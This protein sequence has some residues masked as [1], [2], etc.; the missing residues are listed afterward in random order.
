ML[1]LSLK[2]LKLFDIINKESNTFIRTPEP[3]EAGELGSMYLLADWLYWASLNNLV[4]QERYINLSTYLST[5]PSVG[6]YFKMLS[7]Q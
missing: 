2:N 4:S 7:N 6:E 1:K 3:S 5:I